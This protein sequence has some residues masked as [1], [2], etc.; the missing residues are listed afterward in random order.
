MGFHR[1]LMFGV[2]IVAI[3]SLYIIPSA[4]GR[5]VRHAPID[6]GRLTSIPDS[7][8]PMNV[9]GAYD[10]GGA[11]VTQSTPTQI[12]PVHPAARGLSISGSGVN[13][14]APVSSS[15]GLIISPPGVNE[16]SAINP[17]GGNLSSNTNTD[18]SD[19]HD[20]SSLISPPGAV[21]GV[22]S[23]RRIVHV[24]R[25]KHASLSVSPTSNDLG[26]SESNVIPSGKISSD[27]QTSWHVPSHA[28]LHQVIQGW[29]DRVGWQLN[30]RPDYDYITVAGAD[31]QDMTFED[32]I[33]V[34]IGSYKDASPPLVLDTYPD[35]HAVV[36]SSPSSSDS[37]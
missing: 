28:S 10:G 29:C 18:V 15:R 4:Y 11:V 30:W 5:P 20:Q 19:G 31:L 17:S 14:P 36:I 27:T 6:D 32:A 37:N 33:S 35:N 25:H 9:D 22:T 16:V 21:G 24:G 23:S 7:S 12:N 2:C 3:S 34:V 13:T 8:V 26:H 1:F